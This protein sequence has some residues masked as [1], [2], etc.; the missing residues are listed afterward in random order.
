MK[1]NLIRWIM[2]KYENMRFWFYETFGERTI[3]RHYLGH[4]D[5]TE[6]CGWYYRGKFVPRDTRKK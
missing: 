2:F 3:D 5:F 1:L 4:N 6:E